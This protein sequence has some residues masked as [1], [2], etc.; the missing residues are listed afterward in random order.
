MVVFIKSIRFLVI[1]KCRPCIFLLSYLGI[2]LFRFL[3]SNGANEVL[4]S[5]ELTRTS[6]YIQGVLALCG[7]NDSEGKP[8]LFCSCNDNTVRLYELPSFTERGRL[9]SKREI[10][11]I[12]RGPFP[13]FFTGDANGSLTVWKWLKKPEEVSLGSS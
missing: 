1:F 4:N 9:F 7:M 12:E 3:S 10:R 11:V 13:L 6:F 5:Y 2:I 8:V